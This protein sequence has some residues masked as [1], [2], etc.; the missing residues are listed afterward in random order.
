MANAE[1]EHAR[2]WKDHVKHKHVQIGWIVLAKLPSGDIKKISK[3]F[4]SKD[5]ADQFAA[6]ARSSGEHRDAYVC[7]NYGNDDRV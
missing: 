7:E 2:P 4:S 1:R 3:N 5:A 6:L